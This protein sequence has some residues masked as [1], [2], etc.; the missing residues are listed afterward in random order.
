VRHPVLRS[1]RDDGGLLDLVSAV[2]QAF[3]MRRDSPG[4][5]W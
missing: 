1:G 3:A 4:N 2:A 5:R